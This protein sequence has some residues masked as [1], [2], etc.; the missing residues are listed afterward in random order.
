MYYLELYFNKTD[1]LCETAQHTAV[2]EVR[3]LTHC[4]QGMQRLSTPS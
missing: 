1:L 2:T 3:P 4:F